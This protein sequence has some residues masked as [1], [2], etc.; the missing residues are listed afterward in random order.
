MINQF[1]QK[2]W[3]TTPGFLALSM[4]FIWAIMAGPAESRM[5]IDAPHNSANGFEC[6]AC[7]GV[8]L[9]AS[10][11]LEYEGK[12]ALE[13][14]NKDI[15]FY[16][17]LCAKCH[18]EP[19]ASSGDL[20]APVT[21]LHSSRETN[22]SYWQGNWSRQCIDCHNPH[23]QEQ[24]FWL[25][26]E[27][28]PVADA[29]FYLSQGEITGCSYDTASNSTE[30]KF[31]SIRYKA[32]SIWNAQTLLSK[33]ESGRSTTIFPDIENLRMSF[34]LLDIDETAFTITVKGDAQAVWY[35]RN[36]AA[37]SIHFGIIYGQLI[38]KNI[39]IVLDGASATILDE[40]PVQF[41]DNQGAGSF[42]NDSGEV[43]G[44]CEV[45]H[46]KTRHFTFDGIG[47]DGIPDT[48]HTKYLSN[49]G[50]PAAKETCTGCHLHGQGFAAPGEQ[51]SIKGRN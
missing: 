13:P 23:F 28:N 17:L 8:D 32:D 46:S 51:I 4:M 22:S 11:K 25:S 35:K 50:G 34:I 36:P 24:K 10:L 18:K 40:R 48:P 6:E 44:I 15:T 1:T 3:V 2:K 41:F 29:D 31:E 33:N 21:A 14:D 20:P 26:D 16:N 12:I 38:K 39:P 49:K 30:F 43:L 19:G 42:I 37:E 7:H 45:C 27:S 9:L 47:D 5:S